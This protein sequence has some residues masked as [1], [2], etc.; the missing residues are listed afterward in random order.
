MA[1]VAVAD[2]IAGGTGTAVVS[3]RGSDGETACAAVTTSRG[4]DGN[5]GAGAAAC[6]GSPALPGLGDGSCS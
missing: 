6:A 3:S 1:G 2:R 4:I 5:T